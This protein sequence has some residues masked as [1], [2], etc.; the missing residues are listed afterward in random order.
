M[1]EDEKIITVKKE[2]LTKRHLGWNKRIKILE[3]NCTSLKEMLRMAKTK[4]NGQNWQLPLVQE[5][6]T[7]WMGVEKMQILRLLRP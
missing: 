2:I 7:L 3:Y 5:S 6:S 4:T 1:K